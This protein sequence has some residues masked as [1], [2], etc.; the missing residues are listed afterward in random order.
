MLTLLNLN[1]MCQMFHVSCVSPLT[2]CQVRICN[3]K[4]KRLR[5]M[6]WHLEHLK[7]KRVTSP[8]FSSFS[9]ISMRVGTAWRKPSWK[10]VPISS[11]WNTPWAFTRNPQMP[12]SRNI[13]A[14]KPLKVT[15]CLCLYCLS[16][17]Q[18]N[19]GYCS[20]SQGF[21]KETSNM[22]YV[23][24]TDDRLY[25]IMP[26][27]WFATQAHCV[28]WWICFNLFQDNVDRPKLNTKQLSKFI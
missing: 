24:C 3:Y 7:K 17:C 20:E 19:P 22:Q 21:F 13:Y 18:D 10:R 5:N 1:V 27:V 11:P 28:R 12:W 6:V 25:V 4:Y 9:N 14:P 2:H 26:N 15:S 8:C 16:H 23:L